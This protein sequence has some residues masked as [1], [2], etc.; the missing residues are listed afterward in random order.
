MMIHPVAMRNVAWAQMQCCGLWLHVG[1]TIVGLFPSWWFDSNN[2]RHDPG[3]PHPLKFGVTLWA[4]DRHGGVHTVFGV[5]TRNWRL[6][7]S[8]AFAEVS[9]GHPVGWNIWRRPARRVSA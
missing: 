2:R 7:Y 3:S 5:E 9:E 6:R 4:A 1:G 8:R